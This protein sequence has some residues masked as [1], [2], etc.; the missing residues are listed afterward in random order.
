[1]IRTIRNLGRLFAI[2][3]TLAKHDAL[4]LFEG[5]AEGR[6]LAKLVRLT[7][8]PNPALSAQRP[9]QRLAAALTS[10]GPT[11]SLIHI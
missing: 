9:G 7:A 2:G 6:T 10:L 3:R 8:K 11:L 1:M 5:Y 4:F